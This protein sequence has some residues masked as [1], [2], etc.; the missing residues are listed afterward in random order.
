[1]YYNNGIADEIMIE[2]KRSKFVI[3][4]F[5]YN[6]RGAYFEAGYAQGLGRPINFFA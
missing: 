5:T 3:V 6:N 1:L 2:S 4:D